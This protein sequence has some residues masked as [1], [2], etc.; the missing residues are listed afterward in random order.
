MSQNA[1]NGAKMVVPETSLKT[2]GPHR[3]F[4]KGGL[5]LISLLEGQMKSINM[6]SLLAG[7]IGQ[8]PSPS[9][10]GW[11]QVY[12]VQQTDVEVSLTLGKVS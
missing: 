3:T 4:K 7:Y 10:F 12:T 8:P 2:C 6:A 1:L 11:P 9:P 5:E